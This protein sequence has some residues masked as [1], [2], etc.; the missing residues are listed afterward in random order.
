MYLL[1]K[2]KAL[3]DREF[4]LQ[5]VGEA[6]LVEGGDHRQQQLDRAHHDDAVLGAS[7]INTINEYGII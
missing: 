6:Q 5:T 3:G 2:H 7:A 1:E 4:V